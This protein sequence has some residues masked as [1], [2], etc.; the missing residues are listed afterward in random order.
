MYSGKGFS[1]ESR[2]LSKKL[3]REAFEFVGVPMSGGASGSSYF[4]NDGNIRGI[5][6]MGDPVHNFSVGIKIDHVL[7]TISAQIGEKETK[8]I[9][10]SCVVNEETSL[11]LEDVMSLQPE[12]EPGSEPL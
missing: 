2:N 1:L 8:K 7:D 3:Y 12:L 4:D 6:I 9:F 11:L 10:N 5:Q